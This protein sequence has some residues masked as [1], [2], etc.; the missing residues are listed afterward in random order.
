MCMVLSMSLTYGVVIVV[1]LA[2]RQ[3]D[4]VLANWA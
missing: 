3:E 4:C 1:L 2:F